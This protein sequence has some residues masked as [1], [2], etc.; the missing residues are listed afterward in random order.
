MHQGTELVRIQV[1]RVMRLGPLDAWN[2]IVAS[3]G[4][5][6]RCSNYLKCSGS[7]A[8]RGPGPVVRND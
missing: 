8:E 6:A 2:V 4:L 7:I 3:V 1:E 5:V